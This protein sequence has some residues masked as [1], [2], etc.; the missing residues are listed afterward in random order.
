MISIVIPLYNKENSIKRTLDS[1]L[2]QTSRN[3][4]VVIVDDGSTDGSAEIVKGYSCDNINY[5]YKANGGV[6]SARN[7]GIQKAKGEWIMILDADDCLIDSALDDFYSMI[8]E[9]QADMY[10]AG[11][12]I[13]LPER[14]IF[15]NKISKPTYLKDNFRD[16][17]FL[18][19]DTRAGAFVVKK[20]I[21]LRFSFDENLSLNEDMKTVHEYLRNCRTFYSPKSVMIYKSDFSTLSKV[22]N[23]PERDFR[24]NADLK[25]KPF[26]E[27]MLLAE[28]LARG[29]RDY[30]SLRFDIIKKYN[31]YMPYVFLSIIF[32]VFRI[33]QLGR[34]LILKL[35]YNIKSL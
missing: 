3:Y 12:Y 24:I 16:S 2:N 27:Q 4:E 29:I 28:N 35:S 10:M 25:N 26:W 5:Y 1:V 23:K 9:H 17:Y 21:A 6:S 22:Y 31:K 20:E 18:V 19:Y 33:K 34:L 8:E 11:F 13:E 30:K 15:V 14:R 32:H 7:Y